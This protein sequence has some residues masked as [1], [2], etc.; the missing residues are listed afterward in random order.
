MKR[1]NLI[2]LGLVVAMFAYITLR[3]RFSLST[4]E[5]AER[6]SRVVPGLVR[7]R[8]RAIHVERGGERYAIRAN[9]RDGDGDPKFRFAS[10]TQ[11][12]ADADLVLS[13]ISAAEWGDPVRTL[14]DVD[15][16][17]KRR[18][19]LSHPR[20][21]VRFDVAD[22]TFSLAFGVAEPRGAGVYA[23]SDGRFFVVSDELFQAFD[24]SAEHFRVKRIAASVP[25]DARSLRVHSSRADVA[26]THGEDGWRMTTPYA[27]IASEGRANVVLSF[28]R[29]L[30][31][32]RF[33]DEHPSDVSRYGLDRPTLS[34]DVEGTSAISLRVG[35]TCAGH[36]DER[37][38]RVG[39]GPVVCV[40]DSEVTPLDVEPRAYLELRA[41]L[42]EVG[43]VKGF[44]LHDGSSTLSVADEDGTFRFTLGAT[45]GDADPES[46]EEWLDGM[47]GTRATDVVSSVEGFSP[48]VTLT[49]HRDQSRTDD[50][51]RFAKTPDGSWLARRGDEPILLRFGASLDDRLAVSTI[52]VRARGLLHEDPTALD[53]ISIERAGGREV[54]RRAADGSLAIVEPPGFATE[55]ARATDLALRLAGLEAVRFVSDATRP[56]YGLS[57]PRITLRFRFRGASAST[58]H[59][60]VV[61]AS[62]PVGEPGA[63]ARLD[64]MPV[65][66]ALHQ[67]TLELFES[68]LV[69]RDALVTESLFIDA[70]DVSVG[71]KTVHLV[72]DGQ[73]FTLDGVPLAD[74]RAT[75]AIHG[76]A[77]LRAVAVLGYGAPAASTGLVRPS[78]TLVVHRAAESSEP[79]T[80]TIAFGG[81]AGSGTDTGVAARRADLAVTYV[82]PTLSVEPIAALAR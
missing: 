5:T 53:E 58:E 82:V 45:H 70:L 81:P 76:V 52:H 62:L 75:A 32:T 23:E 63:Y 39:A 7:D 69:S 22:Q 44:D 71:G 20:V 13:A 15:A 8:L 55:V 12:E 74:D 68:P 26:L 49:V 47:R 21:T 11:A 30:S 67:A 14:T 27:A 54:L 78:M 4:G 61:G 72:R 34:V 29:T 33:V 24:Q 43:G 50:V 37:Y 10:P 38:A 51:I 66:F 48:T 9:G 16:A 65:V 36:A 3:E 60:L 1:T 31:A 40:S 64:D 56:E 79:R 59:R 73:R 19:G 80:M 28:L 17:A 77:D 41:M 42:T 46:V 57:A 35:G 6:E 18:Y 2:I 25:A